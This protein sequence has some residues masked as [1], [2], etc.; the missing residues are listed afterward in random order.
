MVKAKVESLG[1]IFT[2]SYTPHKSDNMRMV[3]VKLDNELYQKLAD[4][5][6]R[7]EKSMANV[8]REALKKFLDDK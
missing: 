5:A 8:I 2:Q 3:S 7:N 6:E 4:Y 1:K